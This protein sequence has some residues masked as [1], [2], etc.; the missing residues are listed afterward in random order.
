VIA[1]V[2]EGDFASLGI[3]GAHIDTSFDIRESIVLG[4]AWSRT[5]C[6]LKNLG[7]ALFHE[8]R[9]VPS[10]AERARETRWR[11]VLGGSVDV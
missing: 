3:R 8:S 1:E 9:L 4:A 5:R 7:A 10:V 11:P 2:E 6:A